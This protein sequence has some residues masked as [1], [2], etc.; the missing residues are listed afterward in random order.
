MIYLRVDS[1]FPLPMPETSLDFLDAPTPATEVVQEP[2][3]VEALPP[4]LQDMPDVPVG[5]LQELVRVL[6]EN[7]IYAD[8]FTK[9]VA[10]FARLPNGIQELKLMF[11]DNLVKNISDIVDWMPVFLKESENISDSWLMIESQKK[12]KIWEEKSKIWEEITNN[13]HLRESVDV[14]KSF[15]SNNPEILSKL[16]ER[17]V[18]VVGETTTVETE[19]AT[20]YPKLSP[21]DRRSQAEA[22][23]LLRHRDVIIEVTP[24]EKR[25]ELESLFSGLDSAARQFDSVSIPRASVDRIPDTI[26]TKDIIRFGSTREGNIIQS[27]QTIQQGDQTWELSTRPPRKFIESNGIRIETTA[28][29]ENPYANLARIDGLHTEKSALESSMKGNAHRLNVVAKSLL[30]DRSDL[31]N[32]DTSNPDAFKTSAAELRWLLQDHFRKQFESGELSNEADQEA[33]KNIL[34]NV[35]TQELIEETTKQIE[36]IREIEDMIANLEAAEARR[37][38]DYQERVKSQDETARENLRFLSSIGLSS[39][40]QNGTEQLLDAI[41]HQREITKD[42]PIA[43]DVPLTEQD[44]HSLA[45]MLLQL[46]GDEPPVFSKEDSTKLLPDVDTNHIKERLRNAQIINKMGVFDPVKFE[47]KM[48]KSE[49]QK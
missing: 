40:G 21:E 2:F 1:I 16:A 33:A 42:A 45:K 31:A 44:R 22:T 41:N 7:P 27:G 49:T 15:L 13:L 37:L 17:G 32:I 29:Y 39:L 34:E 24:T 30:P 47:E 28:R 25:K 20:K 12:S 10:N 46:I 5:R 26:M 4:E 6:Q 3:R 8:R 43:L 38:P 35:V 11:H 9:L 36:R 48:K 14:L 19:L 18:D 23:V